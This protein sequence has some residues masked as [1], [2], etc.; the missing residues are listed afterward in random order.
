MLA[1]FSPDREITGLRAVNS[2]IPRGNSGGGR[3]WQAP[4]HSA[5]RCLGKGQMDDELLP[6][7][8]ARYL[9]EYGTGAGQFCRERAEHADSISDTLS[10]A[11]WREIADECDGLLAAVS[12]R[13]KL[14]DQAKG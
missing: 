6:V 13:T 2:D 14:M 4:G 11:T 1:F 7:V 12:E 5:D 10:S 8:A 3:R 9:V